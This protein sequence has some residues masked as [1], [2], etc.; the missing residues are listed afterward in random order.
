M[1][2]SPGS[3]YMKTNCKIGGRIKLLRN[4]PSEATV[5]AELYIALAELKSLG[6]NFVL[7]EPIELGGTVTRRTRKPTKVVVDVLMVDHEMFAIAA[8]EVKND[9]AH[10]DRSHTRQYSKY[11]RLGLPFIYC[12][13]VSDIPCAVE[14]AKKIALESKNKMAT[15]GT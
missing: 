6:V 8:I 9:S 14:W 1:T 4:K 15:L 5:Q 2:K 3:L 10:R 12:P 7:N 13:G 11:T